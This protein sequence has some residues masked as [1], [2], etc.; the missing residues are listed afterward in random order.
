MSLAKTMQQNKMPEI[1]RFIKELYPK[2]D[3]IP[4]HE[5]KFLG[6]E[7]KMLS[8]C[9][10]S[11]FVSSVGEYVDRFEQLMVDYT[12][13][14]YA[15]ATANG[16]SALHMSLMLADVKSGDE[17]LTQAI[18]FVATSNS[19]AYCGAQPIFIDSEKSS[20]GMC[21]DKL[22]EFLKKH[23]EVRNDGFCYNIKTN[24]I[25]RACV[26][27]HVFGHPVKIKQIA[28]TCR[29]YNIHLIEDAAEA[30]GSKIG[31]QH[32]GHHGQSAILSFNGNKIITCGGGGM[33]LTN[34]EGLA[35]KA[36]HLTTTAK[37]SH[38]WEFN[39]DEIG[40]N[41]RLP[42][43][44]AA[45]AC[46]QMESLPFFLDNKRETAAMY[47]E[48]FKNLDVPFVN[49]QQGT[50]ANYWLN[51]ILLENE[52]EKNNFLKQTNEQGIMTRPFWTMLNKLKMYQHCQTTN[53]DRAEELCARLVNLPSSV[54]LA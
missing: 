11:T 32:V 37:I 26:P 29:A 39:H 38:A 24:C 9:I 47:A 51:A 4:L 2:K 17:V 41:Y 14:K 21:P 10:D 46:A 20:L 49:E 36:K 53:L 50:K 27:M 23:A 35:K 30:L 34:D 22:A 6:K 52:S 45:L 18:T 54:R 33:I 40:Y 8:D 15:V 16:T 7:K 3:M 44:N 25:I 43:I 12:K 31:D 5:P 48:F 19:I 1:I 13:I 42:N 28:E